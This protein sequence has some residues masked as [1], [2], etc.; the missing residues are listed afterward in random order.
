MKI[1]LILVFFVINLLISP[2]LIGDTFAEYMSPR[3]QWIKFADPELLTCKEGF[4]LLQKNNGFPACVMPTTYLKLID[5]GFTKFD[6]TLIHNRH[7]MITSLMQNM[8]SNQNLMS[9]WHD[10][11]KNNP[12][13]LNETISNWI[14]S[15]KE[16]PKLLANIMGPLTSEPQL[17]EKMI[18]L[19][20]QHPVMENSLKQNPAWMNSVHKPMMENGMAH[21]MHNGC[22][23]CPEYTPQTM[24]YSTEI[25]PEKIM[26]LIHHFWINDQMSHDMHEFMLDNPEHMAMMSEQ[27]MPQMLVPMMDDPQLREMMIELMLDNQEFMDSIRH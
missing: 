7:V 10:M 22:S 13:I 25:N 24:S 12:H 2:L 17:R 4:I 1:L 18:E 8:V 5:R 16:N 19:M 15:M 9:H 3:Q 23:W 26:D 20:K 14:V 21:D 11:L 6:F 27:L